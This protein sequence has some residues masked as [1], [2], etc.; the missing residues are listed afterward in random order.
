QGLTDTHAMLKDTRNLVTWK[1][2][3]QESEIDY[4]KNVQTIFYKQVPKYGS[5]NE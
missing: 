5:S 1:R 3:E 4:R 2:G